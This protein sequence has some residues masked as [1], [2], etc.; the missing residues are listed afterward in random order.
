MLCES[1]FAMMR[2][3]NCKKNV[4][5]RVLICVVVAFSKR[6]DSDSQSCQLSALIRHEN[7][8]QLG[9]EVL[10]RKKK[11]QKYPSYM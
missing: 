4:R 5:V 1:L 3:E 8:A 9:D 2:N 11:C 6:P 10:F 7:W